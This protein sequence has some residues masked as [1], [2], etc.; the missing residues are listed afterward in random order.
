[1]TVRDLSGLTSR[2][3]SRFARARRTSS[4]ADGDLAVITSQMRR[5]ADRWSAEIAAR[6]IFRCAS[7]G[8]VTELDGAFAR[9]ARIGRAHGHQGGEPDVARRPPRRVAASV[10]NVVVHEAAAWNSSRAH[11]ARSRF[12]E[13]SAAHGAPPGCAVPGPTPLA[14]R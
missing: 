6:R 3:Y 4:T 10:V 5:A 7:T 13:I 14:P 11:P 2:G 9:S 1:M 12:R 8:E